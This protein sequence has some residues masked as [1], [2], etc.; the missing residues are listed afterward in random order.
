MIVVSYFENAQ[1]NL[2]Y[3]PKLLQMLKNTSSIAAWEDGY[4]NILLGIIGKIEWLL[5]N[6]AYS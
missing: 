4:C 1:R 6:I 3:Q 2:R 5:G